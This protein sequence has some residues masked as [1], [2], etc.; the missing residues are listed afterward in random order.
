MHFKQ[1][2]LAVLCKMH[3]EE[4]NGMNKDQLGL[5]V[6]R[7]SGLSHHTPR[8]LRWPSHFTEGRT[9]RA[10]A[11]RLS[12]WE[13]E[14]RIPRTDLNQFLSVLTHLASI[15]QAIRTFRPSSQRKL[16]LESL[17]S[18]TRTWHLQVDLH[19]VFFSLFLLFEADPTCGPDPNP[20]FTPPH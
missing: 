9:N 19:T 15:Y 18:S 6:P 10:K 11:T 2:S 14:I 3:R 7:S 1:L 5:T 20:L 13:A 16:P 17:T 8:P 12:K 4:M